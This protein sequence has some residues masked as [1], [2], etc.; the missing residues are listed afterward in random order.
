MLSVYDCQLECY[1]LHRCFFVA[2][3]FQMK[4][5]SVILCRTLP[6][7]MMFLQLTIP[8][9]KAEMKRTLDWLVPIATNT[10]K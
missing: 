3:L 10:T 6:L 2:M 5:P 7:N 9:I 1:Y 8:Q 4:F